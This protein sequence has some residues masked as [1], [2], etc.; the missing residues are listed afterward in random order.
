MKKWSRRYLKRVNDI[1]EE[2]QNWNYLMCKRTRIHLPSFKWFFLFV[3]KIERFLMLLLLLHFLLVFLFQY[4]FH[5]ISVTH[6]NENENYEKPEPKGIG[7]ER[8]ARVKW[9]DNKKKKHFLMTAQ[10]TKFFYLFILNW[11]LMCCTCKQFTFYTKWK[12]VDR[13]TW[14]KNI[15]KNIFVFRKMWWIKW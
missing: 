7:G 4:H 1:I 2:V 11:N 12:Y 9:N 6:E 5:H 13:Q 15:A 14:K 3:P 8:E 10:K